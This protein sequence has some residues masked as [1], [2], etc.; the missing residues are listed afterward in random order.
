MAGN[1]SN[2]T[3][4]LLMV[5][6]SFVSV[7]ALAQSE[8]QE[9]QLQDLIRLQQEDL[10]EREDEEGD[11]A[12]TSDDFGLARVLK[13]P[14]PFN[15]YS[16]LAVAS[17]GHN[18]NVR[19]DPVDENNDHFNSQVLELA[20]RPNLKTLLPGGRASVSANLQRTIYDEFNTSFSF[21]SFVFETEGS[22]A[23]NEAKSRAIY[24]QLLYQDIFTGQTPGEDSA[25]R[26]GIARL[27]LRQVLSVTRFHQF[28]ADLGVST[29]D[30]YRVRGAGDPGDFTDSS[31]NIYQGS[32]TYYYPYSRFFSLSLSGRYEFRDYQYQGAP[33]QFSTRDEREDNRVIGTAG[34]NYRFLRNYTA[35]LNGTIVENDS[36]QQTLL[37]QDRDYTQWRVILGVQYNTDFH[38]FF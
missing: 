17:S 18:S 10:P 38:S 33:F 6:L 30:A 3:A 25:Q 22:Y 26:K 23:L 7:A 1:S 21:S 34:F 35:R 11:D 31:K 12:E 19:L 24:A 37:G 32:L 13:E 28:I 36:N 16:V 20:Y 14:E 9:D 27:G 15:Y 29:E 5:L 8:A 4:I 2:L